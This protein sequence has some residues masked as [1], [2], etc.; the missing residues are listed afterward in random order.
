M[1]N[2][3]V[4][5]ASSLFCFDLICHFAFHN[6]VVLKLWNVISI[7]I[8]GYNSMSTSYIACQMVDSLLN[9]HELV[10]HELW[11]IGFKIEH[12]KS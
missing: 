1:C 8:H 3:N 4:A 6:H 11:W 5:F 9:A 2:L 10:K 12:L 7:R